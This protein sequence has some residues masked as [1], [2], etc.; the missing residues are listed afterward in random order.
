MRSIT[1][2]LLAGM[3]AVAA[4]SSAHA[5][6]IGTKVLRGAAIGYAVKQAAGPLDSFINKVTL[7]RGVPSNLDT[8]VVP[9]LSVGEK[10]YVGGAQVS[11]PASL[12]KDVRAVFQYEQ[13]FD[14][15]RYRLKGL[16]PSSS[17]N[18]LKLD[19]VAKVGISALID[20]SLAGGLKNNY[21]SG[22]VG[23][24]EVLR[25][26][27]V[28]VAVKA[29]ADPI[30]KA[31]NTITFNKNG[32]TE[33]VPMA[34]F[35]EK[36]YIGGAQV[37]GS[38]TVIEDVAAVWQYE[39]LFSNGRFRVRVLVPTNS[40]NPLKMKRVHG[41]GL[42]AVV[43]T[44]IADQQTR[45]RDRRSRTYR[46]GDDRYDGRYRDDRDDDDYYRHDRGKHKGWY[47]GKHKGWDKNKDKGKF[48]E[49]DKWRERL[50]RESR[51]TPKEFDRWWEM[52][53]NDSDKQLESIY[54]DFL[55][56]RDD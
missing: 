13:N 4:L 24:G 29:V 3:I 38:T 42:T 8:K 5:V 2:A 31:I 47:I 54:L 32:V 12:V 20:V 11:G 46:P 18:P 19:R 9:I 37:S 10:G 14:R 34:S 17:I 26:A 43:E 35:G 28:A 45:D 16:V 53:K 21:Y 1:T 36:A 56:K 52:H 6:S 23:A 22:G 39:D 51:M 7:Q 55:R 25:A 44:S 40:S 33:V 48:I 50:Y 15:G 30:D 27:A 41:A 49:R